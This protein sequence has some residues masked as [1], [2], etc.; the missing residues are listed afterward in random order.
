MQNEVLYEGCRDERKSGR[1][2]PTGYAFRVKLYTL[3]KVGRY[4][5]FR[6]QQL[7]KHS[8]QFSLK[9]RTSTAVQ[10]AV[11]GKAA[12]IQSVGLIWCDLKSVG[13][14]C[15]VEFIIIPSFILKKTML[16]CKV[17][18]RKRERDFSQKYI[19]HKNHGRCR[20]VTILNWPDVLGSPQVREKEV[21][22]QCS[23]LSVIFMVLFGKKKMATNNPIGYVYNYC[24][25]VLV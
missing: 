5:G 11:V 15:G 25:N 9:S 20:S 23:H 13:T 14:V 2:L 1:C 8:P 4:T 3:S 10:N 19:W 16:W 6:Q 18:V 7:H 24:K 21:S 17:T 22:V 12:L